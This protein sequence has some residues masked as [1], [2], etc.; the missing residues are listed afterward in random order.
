MEDMKIVFLGDVSVGKSTLITRYLTNVFQTE[1]DSTVEDAYRKM[2]T[3][4]GISVIVELFDT[5]GSFAEYRSMMDKVMR[6]GMCF[7]LVYS[8]TSK[9]SFEEIDAFVD[10]VRMFKDQDKFP[11]VLV[12]NKSDLN[13][14]EVTE[15]EGEEKAS[16]YNIPYVEASAKDGINVDEVLNESVRQIRNH[17]A[18]VVHCA[19][20]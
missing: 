17:P 20:K 1:I 14:R 11:M 16:K 19:R 4:D 2:V 5:A 10:A 8:I 15:I 13:D 9:K 3:I 6:D 12:G 7:V 18:P